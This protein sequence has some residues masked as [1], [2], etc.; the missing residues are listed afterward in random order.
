MCL[1]LICEL[2]RQSG[3]FSRGVESKVGS[4]L[5]PKINLAKFLAKLI[6]TCHI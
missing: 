1:S 3:V 5:L 2:H 4:N 6:E